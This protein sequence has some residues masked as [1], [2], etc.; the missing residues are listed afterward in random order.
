M[1]CGYANLSGDERGLL[2]FRVKSQ[3]S[4]RLTREAEYHI[5]R[6]ETRMDGIKTKAAIVPLHLTFG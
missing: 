6:C 5:T 2:T 1:K 3:P 4:S